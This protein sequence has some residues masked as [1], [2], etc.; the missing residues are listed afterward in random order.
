MCQFPLKAAASH[1]PAEKY[2]H[3]DELTGND[4]CMHIKHGT[5]ETLIL[6][7]F[8]LLMF[9][10]FLPLKRSQIL[11]QLSPSNQYVSNYQLISDNLDAPS[12]TA[13]SQNLFKG[14]IILVYIVLTWGIFLYY[15]LYI[16]LYT[17]Y[18]KLYYKIKGTTQ[19]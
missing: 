13:F 14:F 6:C 10:M 8:F 7:S 17:I 18:Y 19:Q 12:S 1:I 2:Q 5:Q 16:I 3:A 4:A 9:G 15:K 11:T